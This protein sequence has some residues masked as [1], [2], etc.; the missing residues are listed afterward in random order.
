[1]RYIKWTVCKNP[2]AGAEKRK[3][4]TSK[5]LLSGTVSDKQQQNAKAKSKNV[6][7]TVYLHK[8]SEVY[9]QGRGADRG[10]KWLWG[11]GNPES[12]STSVSTSSSASTRCC[13]TNRRS[14]ANGWTN[15]TILE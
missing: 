11:R 4:T 10:G 6:S 1:M 7:H 15:A 5:I 13:Q 14:M 8:M 3:E 9:V 2:A 12:A